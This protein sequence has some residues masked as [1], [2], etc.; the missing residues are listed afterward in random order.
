MD[1]DE[2]DGE[3][4]RTRDAGAVIGVEGRQVVEGL[5]EG[6]IG[7]GKGEDGGGSSWCHFRRLKS[8]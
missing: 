8:G 1:E 3:V 6:A 5:F 7:N 2:D 4:S